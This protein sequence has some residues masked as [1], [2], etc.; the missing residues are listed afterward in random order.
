VFGRGPTAV[1]AIYA[2]L[3][4]D[5]VTEIVLEAPPES[6][7]DPET[8]ELLGVLRI[9]DLPHNL[10]LAYPRPITF[11]G[12]MPAAYE[13]TKQAYEKL[14]QAHRVRVVENVGQWRPTGRTP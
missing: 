3:L 4:D 9:G 8:P 10:A 11:I 1:H 7:C 13:W 12:E 5:E 14:G 2:A 6:H